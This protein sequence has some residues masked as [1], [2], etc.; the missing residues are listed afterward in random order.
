VS[1][2]CTSPGRTIE[3]GGVPE[4]LKLGSF[5]GPA[6]REDNVPGHARHLLTV[7]EHIDERSGSAET[8][9]LVRR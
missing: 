2:M 5:R 3:E 4:C 7:K 1:R 9:V 8:T 6:S